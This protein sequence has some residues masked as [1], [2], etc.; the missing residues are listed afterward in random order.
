M[1]KISQDF[2][3]Q[4]PAISVLKM[5]ETIKNLAPLN[6]LRN[7]DYPYRSGPPKGVQNPR[8]FF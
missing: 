8:M 2:D 5:S 6:P 4:I 1:L 3:L 7:C